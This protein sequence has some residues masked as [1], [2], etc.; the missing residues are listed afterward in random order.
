MLEGVDA[1]QDRKARPRN[2]RALIVAAATELFFTRGYDHVGLGDIAD[3]VGIVPSALYRHFPSRQDLMR[4][5]VLSGIAPAREILVGGASE[6]RDRVVASL[7]SLTLTKPEIGVLWRREARH[8]DEEDR[9]RLAAEIHT[10]GDRLAQLVRASRPEVS[11]D[12]AELLGWS[13]FGVL[14]GTTRGNRGLDRARTEALITE[15]CLTVLDA[16]LP[17]CAA[18]TAA[19]P[20]ERVVRVSRREE[21]LDHAVRLFAERGFARVGLDDI[22][23]SV[24]IAGPS[25]YKHF[26]GKG[27]ILVAAV[28]RSVEYLRMRVADAFASGGDAKTILM[29]A[30]GAYV[31]F[32]HEHP[33]LV[34]LILTERGHLPEETQKF[35]ADALSE[36]VAEMVGLLTGSG[37]MSTAEAKVR[38]TGVLAMTNDIARTPGLRKRI[39]VAPAVLA[40]G[41]QLL[42][43]AD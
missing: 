34:T 43:P 15:L 35:A 39:E 21:I 30:F 4:E 41:E 36:V 14:L 17:E 24:G 22:G 9:H 40:L 27:E 11:A 16:E 13:M 20:A 5:V 12:M 19:E 25:V 8:L 37:A 10:V 6:D 29:R 18:P 28:V 33:D 42:L 31:E 7:V 23:A 38:V 3:A 32:S 1:D 2:R 26:P